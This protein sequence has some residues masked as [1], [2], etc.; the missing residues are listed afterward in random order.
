MGKFRL[1]ECLF[2]SLFGEK[3]RE[4]Q[5]SKEQNSTN[6]KEKVAKGAARG[7]IAFR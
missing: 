5:K 3:G 6:D 1:F 7:G 4:R 2:V